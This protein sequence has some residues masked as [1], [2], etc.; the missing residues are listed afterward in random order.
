[1][2]YDWHATFRI[3]EE[4]EAVAL[5]R[6]QG[7]FRHVRDLYGR[8]KLL[9]QVQALAPPPRWAK[10][11]THYREIV[12]QA[13][14]TT[15]Y[16]RELISPEQRLLRRLGILWPRLDTDA[17]EILPPGSFCL[18]FQFTLEE[19]FVSKD[20]APFYP[21]DNPLRKEWAFKVPMTGGSGWKGNLRAAMRWKNNGQEDDD[22]RLLFG[23]PRPEGTVPEDYFRAGRLRFYP[24]YFDALELEILN[25][26]DRKSGSGR[27]PFNLECVPDG[28]QGVFSLL[29][30]PFDRAGWPWGE[31]KTEVACHLKQ[32]SR[33][34]QAMLRTLGFS[35]KRTSGFGLAAEVVKGVNGKGGGRLIIHADTFREQEPE[36]E[37]ASPV[38]TG[39]PP[40]PDGVDEF[41]VDGEFPILMK[42]K[43]VAA[44]PW[45]NSKKRRYKRARDAYLAWKAALG[46]WEQQAKEAGA[47]KL[48]EFQAGPPL[49]TLRFD[50]F[51]ALVSVADGAAR[52][53]EVKHE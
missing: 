28:G 13:Q 41:I 45:G 37:T 9:A 10:E 31:Y 42:S 16:T 39:P 25:P 36:I 46:A 52:R 1:M 43:E 27:D 50:S 32:V 30:V 51:T 18:Q 23:P 12:H 48:A 15:L 49:Q 53:L 8:L 26:H 11:R 35:A 2:G 6:G 17:L 33:G 24:T 29:Y 3:R 22:L 19:P 20:D 21:H 38:Q 7:N 5:I 14:G 34:L 40:P 47:G 44:Q 4:Q